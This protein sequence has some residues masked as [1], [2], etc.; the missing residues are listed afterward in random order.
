MLRSEREAESREATQ[1]MFEMEFQK[2][3]LLER[4]KALE[5]GKAQM[6]QEAESKYAA[7]QAHFDSELDALNVQASADLKDSQLRS[8]TAL[9]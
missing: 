4:I 6:Q 8:E 3:Q 1:Q 7:A 2:N 9:A 5:A